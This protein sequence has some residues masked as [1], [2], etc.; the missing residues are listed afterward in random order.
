[1]KTFDSLGCSHSFFKSSIIHQNYGDLTLE[2]NGSIWQIHHCLP[3]RSF[4]LLDESELKNC[5][6]LEELTTH[7]V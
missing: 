3:I 4:N 2:K 1:M 5:F 7:V 6:H